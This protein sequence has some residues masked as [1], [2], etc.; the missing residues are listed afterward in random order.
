MAVTDPRRRDVYL[1]HSGGE[2]IYAEATGTGTP[3]VLC[4][5][6]GGNHAIWWRQVDE[7]ARRHRVV[8]WDQ[9]GFGNSTTRTGDVSITAAAADLLAILGELDLRGACLVGQSMGAFAAL[10]AAV[11][12]DSRIGALIISTSLAGAPARHTSALNAALGT[13]SGRD[14]HPVISD[15]FSAAHPDLVVLYNLISSFGR[16]PASAAMIEHMARAV[17]TD[18]ELAGL[19]VPVHLVAAEHDEFCS[20]DVMELTRRRF[21]SAT[22]DILPGASHSAYYEDPASWNGLVLRLAGQ[23][24]ERARAR[25][26]GQ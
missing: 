23:P 13:R 19:P 11:T 4:H 20:P 6:L 1:V 16:K 12:D 25:A 2:L 14:Q 21:R 24:R 10:R 17:F 18:D 3:V 15:A 7:F 5:G 9:R 8:T 26:V 22:L